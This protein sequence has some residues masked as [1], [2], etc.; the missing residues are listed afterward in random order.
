MA[1]PYN[2]SFSTNSLLFCKGR[3]MSGFH[4]LYNNEYCKTLVK[5]IKGIDA[6]LVVE[7]III[8]HL[9]GKHR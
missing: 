5:K 7:N 3:M 1:A 6:K 2:R 9:F 4:N 8:L